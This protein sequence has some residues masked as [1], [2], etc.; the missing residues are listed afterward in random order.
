MAK[1]IAIICT[2]G[3]GHLIPALAVAGELVNRGYRVTLPTT[4]ERQ[5]QVEATGA[6]APLYSSPMHENLAQQAVLAKDAKAADFDP[7]SILPKFLEEA[8]ATAPQFQSI[9]EG[10]RPDLLVY[11]QLTWAGALLAEKW[12]VPHVVLFPSTVPVPEQPGLAGLQR[13]LPADKIAE[14]DVELSAAR[15]RIGLG[16]STVA[17]FFAGTPELGVAFLT[18]SFQPFGDS[19]GEW[20]EFV[21]PCFGERIDNV[22]WQ[23][24]AGTDPLVYVSFGSVFNDQPSFFRTVIEAFRDEPVRVVMAIGQRVDRAELGEIPPN[25]EVLGFAP[26]LEILPHASV[27]LTHCGMGGTQEGL[28]FGVPLVGIPQMTEQQGN[29]ERV[30]E[31]GLGRHIPPAEVT[32]SVL[33]TAV[34]EVLAD[35]DI[36]ARLAAMQADIRDAGGTARAADVLERA[37][38]EFGN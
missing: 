8:G 15:A 23:P 11:D 2:P 35:P 27:F 7:A 29:A 3:Q 34:R 20:A 12:G 26:Q 21:G 17:D 10:D 24:P 22:G 33:R 13:F 14:L 30:V 37:V 32:A 19:V 36:K 38:K 4:A 25:F 16:P 31:L 5:A 6:A 9:L 28:S 18:R 1:H